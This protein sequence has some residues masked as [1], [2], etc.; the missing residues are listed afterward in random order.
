MLDSVILIE[1]TL[2]KKKNDLTVGT[3]REIDWFCKVSLYLVDGFK[4]KIYTKNHLKLKLNISP[5]LNP[6]DFKF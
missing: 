1:P 3:R 6:I 4:L 2:K 5:P